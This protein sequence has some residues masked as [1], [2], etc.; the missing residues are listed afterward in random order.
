MSACICFYSHETERPSIS[1]D[2]GTLLGCLLGL[3]NVSPY[4]RFAPFTHNASVGLDKCCN[5]AA[6]ATSII[7]ECCNDPHDVIDYADYINSSKRKLM[8]GCYVLPS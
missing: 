6:L 5:A 4:T 7:D 2:A 1:G 8:C 3:H